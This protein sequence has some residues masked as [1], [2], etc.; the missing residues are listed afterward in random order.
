VFLAEIV[1]Q[2]PPILGWQAIDS[3]GFEWL[4]DIRISLLAPFPT[5]ILGIQL[6]GTPCRA[7]DLGEEDFP[8]AAGRLRVIRPASPD[9]SGSFGFS[10]HPPGRKMARAVSHFVQESLD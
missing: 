2:R 5:A 8:R 9:F 4:K 1:R 7:R 6:L 3:F 10:I